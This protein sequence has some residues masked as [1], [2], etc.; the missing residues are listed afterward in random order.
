MLSIP[1]KSREQQCVSPKAG[2]LEVQRAM[3]AG[4][5]LTTQGLKKEAPLT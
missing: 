5:V 2:C 4:I 3:S 1:M